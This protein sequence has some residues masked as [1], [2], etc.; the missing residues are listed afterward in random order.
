MITW[1]F[2]KSKSI[3]FFVFNSDADVN[4][5]TFLDVLASLK[6]IFNCFRLP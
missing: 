5:E 6:T 2:Q 4:N 3:P 1:S